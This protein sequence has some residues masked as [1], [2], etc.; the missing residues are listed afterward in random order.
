MNLPR[1]LSMKFHR[2]LPM[3]FPMDNLSMSTFWGR[4]LELWVSGF[5]KIALPGF[6]KMTLSSFWKM[7]LPGFRKMALSGFQKISYGS[8]F[9]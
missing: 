2:N 6:Q 9:E 5:W 3:K 7:A 4:A 1:K 8:S